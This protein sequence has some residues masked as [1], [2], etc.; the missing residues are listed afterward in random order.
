MLLQTARA[1]AGRPRR[2]PARRRST[3]SSCSV[4]S[5]RTPTTRQPLRRR[6]P[7]DEAQLRGRSAP[8]ASVAVAD[9]S[10]CA[11]SA[12]GRR[13]ARRSRAGAPS[14]PRS[15]PAAAS[16]RGSTVVM[17]TDVDLGSRPDRLRRR[18]DRPREVVRPGR[19]ARRRHRRARRARHLHR[20]PDPPGLPRRRHRR[21]AGRGLGRARSSRATWSRRSRTSPSVARR[22]RDGEPGGHPIDVLSL[23][24]GYYHETP[25]DQL[26]DPTMYDILR[27]AGRVR[28][29]GGLLGRQRRDRAADVPGRLRPWPDADETH[30][31]GRARRR[32]DR[33][34]RR[35]QPQRHRRAVQQRRP[36]G[37]RAT[38]PA[39][40]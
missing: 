25:E 4:A 20:R 13:A 10:R 27:D 15:T 23:S 36:L 18:R 8:T 17:R 16:T 1:E 7:Y 9:A 37:A 34:R 39:P 26:F 31:R 2:P 24:M 3:T 6:Q 12:R 22:H 38:P 40:R 29:R 28:R 35:A 19:A 32:P 33:L 5:T 14:W 21:L 30:R 11:T